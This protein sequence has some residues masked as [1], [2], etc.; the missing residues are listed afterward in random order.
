MKNRFFVD[1]YLTAV[2]VRDSL[3]SDFDESIVKSWEG[4]QDP[5]CG[6]FYVPLEKEVEAEKLCQELN[7]RFNKNNEEGYIS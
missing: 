1:Y 5:H 7:N 2:Y 3:I 6:C 4:V